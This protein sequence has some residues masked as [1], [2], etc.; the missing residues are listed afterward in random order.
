AALGTGP[1][2]AVYN[3]RLFAA[4][5]ANDDTRDLLIKSSADGRNWSEA[6]ASINATVG[7]RGSPALA[8]F[9]RR[10][11]AAWVAGQTR[12][13]MVK[14]AE[15]EDGRTWPVTGIPV[16]VQ[17]A[18]LTSPSLTVFNKHLY[19][20]WIADTPDRDIMIKSSSNGTDW[21]GAAIPVNETSDHNGGVAP[22]RAFNN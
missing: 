13:V 10:L 2:L 1:A 17:A 9:N 15:S 6:P 7:V 19:V 18:P 8:V 14:F 11:G 16:G 22:I 20:S 12:A 4:W 3:N 5:V 21:P